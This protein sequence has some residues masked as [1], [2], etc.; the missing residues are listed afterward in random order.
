M[1]LNV[2]EKLQGQIAISK[3]ITLLLNLTKHTL[4]F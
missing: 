4:K 3:P 2:K 1:K